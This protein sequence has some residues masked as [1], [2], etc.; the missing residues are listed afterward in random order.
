MG[1]L[2]L[3]TSAVSSQNRLDSQ[4]LTILENNLFQGSISGTVLTVAPSGILFPGQTIFVPNSSGSLVS[5]TISG[6]GSL[7]SSGQTYMLSSSFSPGVSSALILSS[8]VAAIAT[9]SIGNGVVPTN[10]LT[11]APIVGTLFGSL[12][13][14]QEISGVGI[15]A[16]TF[17][18]GSITAIGTITGYTLNESWNLPVQNVVASWPDK[19]VFTAS[20]PASSSLLTVTA[21]SS[22]ALAIGQVLVGSNAT[23]SGSL[24]PIITGVS[25]GTTL[26]SAGTYTL[27]GTATTSIIGITLAAL[28]APSRSIGSVTGSILTIPNT[29]LVLTQ[30]LTGSGILPGTSI[31]AGSGFTYNLSNPQTLGS[32][33]QPV[34]ITASVQMT[35]PGTFAVGSIAGTTLTTTASANIVLAVGQVI[36]GPGIASNTVISSPIGGSTTQFAVAVLENVSTSPASAFNGAAI[37]AGSVSGTS[38]TVASTVVGSVTT[39]QALIGEPLILGSYLSAG[40]AVIVPQ[41]SGSTSFTALTASLVAGFVGSTAMTYSAISPTSGSLSALQPLA[42]SGL[43]SGTTIIGTPT[44]TVA[45]LAISQSIGTIGML[46]SATPVSNVGSSG[47]ASMFYSAT[48]ARPGVV[49]EVNASNQMSINKIEAFSC[50]TAVRAID[51]IDLRIQDLGLDSNT[52]PDMNTTAIDIQ[53]A[54][55]RISLDTAS[56][57]DHFIFLNNNSSPAAAGTADAVRLTNIR[58]SVISGGNLINQLGARLICVGSDLN[59]G[60]INIGSGVSNV[61]FAAT[62]F[63][64]QIGNA[65]PV[66]QYALGAPLAAFDLTCQNVPPSALQQFNLSLGTTLTALYSASIGGTLGNDQGRTGYLVFPS[67]NKFASPGDRQ[68]GQIA[69]GV[70]TTGTTATR[71]TSDGNS[72]ASGG[73]NSLPIGA[74]TITYAQGYLVAYSPTNGSWAAWPNIGLLMLFSSGTLTIPYSTSLG[75]PPQSGGSGNTWRATLAADN[76]SSPSKHCLSVSVTGGTY[77]VHWLLVLNCLDIA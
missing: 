67:G 32:Q 25:T 31:T 34:T 77:T 49:I 76:N 60:Q 21:V 56:V 59:S 30:I 51:A 55:G 15:S 62:G 4:L 44:S 74:D 22:G 5:T 58:A 26:G 65:P 13:I 41:Y 63:G 6:M 11:V 52:T 66:F 7:T 3:Q 1:R 33:V 47:V 45:S 72:V 28:A 61:S 23:F 64:P 17:I 54:G 70:S 16:P 20:I 68:S 39:S 24:P 37:F 36:A 73:A 38:L 57:I 27:S 29:S 48:S 18:T 75:P 14:G 10:T 19:A 8:N 35:T 42:G 53:G 43:L 46:A 69:L 12:A 2:P 40:N 71:L 50:G 9:G